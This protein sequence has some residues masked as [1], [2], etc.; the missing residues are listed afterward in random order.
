M[1]V[2]LITGCSTGIGQEAAIML[3]QAGHQ[4][5]ASCRNP[6]SATELNQRIQDSGLSIP[7]LKLDLLDQQSIDNAVASVVSKSGRLDVLVN[8]AAIGAGRAL[9][10]TSLDEIREVYETNVF[11][12]TAVLKAVIPVM[13][14]QGG[15]RLVNVTSLAAVN[16]FGCHGTYSSS[17]AAMEAIC[18]ALAQEL[19]EHNIE[20][21]MI[22]PGCVLTPM[23]TKGAP[24]PD[25]SPY[26]RSFSRFARWCEF[27]LG[28]AATPADCVAAITDAIESDQPRFRYP[29]GPDA[30]DFWRA[31][32]EL[33]DPEEWM[34]IARMDDEAYA[35]RMLELVGIDYYR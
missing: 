26:M 7:V 24:P 27:G 4:V 18:T 6:E 11:G 14:K 10:E 3:A 23:W 15:G 33:N 34:R 28:R 35:D 1:S 19:S 31:Y 9:E 21:S 12:A 32:T 30:E 8:N 20:V 29:V 17:K 2:I 13:R 5:F 16:V 25:D 22:E